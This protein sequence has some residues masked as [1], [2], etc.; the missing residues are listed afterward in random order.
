MKPVRFVYCYKYNPF[1]VFTYPVKPQAYNS[2]NG[3][4]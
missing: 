3:L 1:G 2:Q 4:S